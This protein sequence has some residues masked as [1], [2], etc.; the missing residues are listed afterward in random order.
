MA[1]G[2]PTGINWWFIAPIYCKLGVLSKEVNS[3][4][5]MVEVGALMRR[6]VSGLGFVGCWHEETNIWRMY[7][8]IYRTVV[9]L[10]ISTSFHMYPPC[11]HMYPP[12][13]NGSFPGL[14]A[15]VEDRDFQ[16]LELGPGLTAPVTTR[17]RT[18][19]GPSVLRVA[20]RSATRLPW[21]TWTAKKLKRP[22]WI[23]WARTGCWG[24]L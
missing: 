24:L 2:F 9:W 15:D 12:C 6:D 23:T 5:A 20:L 11:F 3:R 13:F 4:N 14:W 1:I 10:L 19:L 7:K 18:Q 8:I 16:D 22:S 17:W 21:H